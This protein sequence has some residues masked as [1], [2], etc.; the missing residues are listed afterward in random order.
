MNS[1]YNQKHLSLEDIRKIEEGIE[2]ILH[3]SEIAKS[4]KKIL[5]LSQKKSIR[6]EK[7]G[8]TIYM[9]LLQIN[10]SI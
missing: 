10:V 7:L 5:L 8:L 9:I 3:K 6:I 2:K 4:V 1:I